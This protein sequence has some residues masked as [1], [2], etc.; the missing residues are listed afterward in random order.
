MDCPVCEADVDL[1]NLRIE[2]NEGEMEI[3]FT[4]AGCG[5]EL[6]ALLAPRDFVPVD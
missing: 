6:Y 4:C 3:G 2:D 1:G 5:G